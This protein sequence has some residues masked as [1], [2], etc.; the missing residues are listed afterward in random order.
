MVWAIGDLV[1]PFPAADADP[2][3]H[4]V[5]GSYQAEIRVDAQQLGGQ[6]VRPFRLTAGCSGRSPGAMATPSMR[7]EEM[8]FLCPVILTRTARSQAPHDAAGGPRCNVRYWKALPAFR[9]RVTW[10]DHSR[11][12]I[13]TWFEM[14]S[15]RFR[16][17]RIIPEMRRLLSDGDAAEIQR[18]SNRQ[19][20]PCITDSQG[21]P[22]RRPG[23]S[24]PPGRGSPGRTC[25][26]QA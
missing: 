11:R 13:R 3:P 24:S 21:P 15:H 20:W 22:K 19:T 14:G 16:Q 2:A 5:F 10:V 6:G 9:S 26:V 4:H 1:R 17:P 18:P 7:K 23:T 8:E 25:G 12:I